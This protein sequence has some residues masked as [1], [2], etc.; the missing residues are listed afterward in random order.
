MKKALS[1]LTGLYYICAGVP[2]PMYK[3]VAGMGVEPT[4]DGL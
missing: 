4:T 3:V 2:T 1:I